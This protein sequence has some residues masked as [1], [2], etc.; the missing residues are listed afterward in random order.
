MTTLRISLE[1]P[2]QRLI[3]KARTIAA[4]PDDGFQRTADMKAICD[5]FISISN[6]IQHTIDELRRHGLVS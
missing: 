3:D 4:E 6:Q 1:P 5:E 2:K